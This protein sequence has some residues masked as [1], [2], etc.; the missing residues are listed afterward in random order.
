M[1][2]RMSTILSNI[3]PATLMNPRVME[4][5]RQIH[6]ATEVLRQEAPELL[7]LMSGGGMLPQGAQQPPSGN[8]EAT[9]ASGGGSDR[10]QAGAQPNVFDLA[11]MLQGMNMASFFFYHLMPCVFTLKFCRVAQVEAAVAEARRCSRQ[12]SDIDRS[13]SSSS[14]WASLIRR[15]TLRV[16]GSCAQKQT[17]VR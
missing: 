12:R 3:N 14:Q 17:T 6:A 4:A 5:C 16:C 11:S 13:L 15:R 1:G 8:N 10:P 7:G 2:G 9:S